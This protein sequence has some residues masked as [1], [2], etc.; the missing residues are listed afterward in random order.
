[1]FDYFNPVLREARKRAKEEY[2]QRLLQGK[3]DAMM[4]HAQED[5]SRKLARK[6]T[7]RREFPGFM[8]KLLKVV[9]LLGGFVLLLSQMGR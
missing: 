5:A 8:G 7:F 4:R 9:L 3:A 1:M 6:E 2:K